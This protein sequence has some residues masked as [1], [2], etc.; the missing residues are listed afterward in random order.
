M[1]CKEIRLCQGLVLLLV[2]ILQLF[3]LLW[4]QNKEPQKVLLW[5]E[6]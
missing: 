1:W 4:C 6:A 2:G 5:F 3:L